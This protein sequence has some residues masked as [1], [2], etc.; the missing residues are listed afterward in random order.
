MLR[1]SAMRDA[2]LA[3]GPKDRSPVQQSV[4]YSPAMPHGQKG[5]CAGPS[6]SRAQGRCGPLAEPSSVL[7]GATQGRTT[8]MAILLLHASALCA[9]L[10]TASTCTTA[11]AWTL[12]DHV[13]LH[14]VTAVRNLGV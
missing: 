2:V 5:A 9:N 7:R 12:C 1:A 4:T 14:G 8:A 11:G 3:V 6:R 10:L 13:A